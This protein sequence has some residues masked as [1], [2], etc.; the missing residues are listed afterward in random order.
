[1]SLDPCSQAFRKHE[2]F[3][4]QFAQSEQK[5]KSGWGDASPRKDLNEHS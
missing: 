5:P 2:V 3:Y 1:M 4:H